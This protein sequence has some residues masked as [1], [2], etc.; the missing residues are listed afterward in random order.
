[1]RETERAE[2]IRAVLFFEFPCAKYLS[3]AQSKT[4]ILDGQACL[5][6]THDELPINRVAVVKG[7]PIQKDIP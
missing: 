2:D 1:M 3:I 5:K 6:I 7:I 4:F